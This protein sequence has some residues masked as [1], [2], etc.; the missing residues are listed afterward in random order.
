MSSFASPLQLT[1]IAAV[2]VWPLAAG[3]ALVVWTKFRAAGHQRRLARVET[4]VRGLFREV[5]L[6][7][8]P[9]RLAIVVDALE[10]HDAIA[11]AAAA[12]GRR[13]TKANASY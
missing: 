4:H 9:E 6:Q 2:A 3:L 12:G 7:P 11:A 1:T 5:E 8:V 13:R 10:E